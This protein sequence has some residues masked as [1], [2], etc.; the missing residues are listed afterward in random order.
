MINRFYLFIFCDET[1]NYKKFYCKTFKMI[2]EID[3]QI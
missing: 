3:L 2:N 1:K